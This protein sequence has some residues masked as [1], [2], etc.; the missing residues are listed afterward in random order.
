MHQNATWNSSDTGEVETQVLGVMHVWSCGVLETGHTIYFQESVVSFWLR[1]KITN[2]ISLA[3][4]AMQET[5]I[6]MCF[7]LEHRI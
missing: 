5:L 1:I 2:Y 3:S 6:K 4:T 7:E